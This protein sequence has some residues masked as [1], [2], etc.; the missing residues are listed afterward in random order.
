MWLRDSLPQLAGGTRVLMYGYDAET[1]RSAPP[2]VE[3]L[4]ISLISQLK[5]IDRAS[6]TAKPVVFIV[7]ALAG[8]VLKQT[9]IELANSG[10]TEMF[11]LKSIKSCIF[12]NVP[13][14]Y[15]GPQALASLVGN[16]CFKHL[17]AEL[18]ASPNYL[19]KLDRMMM[20]IVQGHSISI[21]SG[22]D[23]T[24]DALSEVRPTDIVDYTVTDAYSSS[25]RIALRFEGP[26]RNATAQSTS[27][28]MTSSDYQRGARN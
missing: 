7:H 3:G 2:T 17:L 21:C 19:A 27:P 25:P 18:D 13:N 8:V 4:A 15:D 10:Q 23:T 11:M 1:H 28:T 6:L 9:L 24:T 16:S 22:Y 12:L 26:F 20:G 5:A 14:N